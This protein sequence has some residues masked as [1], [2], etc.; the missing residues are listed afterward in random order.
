MYDAPGSS[1]KHIVI[2]KEVALGKKPAICFG[3]GAEGPVAEAL[4]RD[5]QVVGE[6]AQEDEPPAVEAISL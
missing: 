2:D 1:I 6:S 4:D 3:R 5:D